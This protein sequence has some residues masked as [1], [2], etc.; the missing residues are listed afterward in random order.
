MRIN[1]SSKDE[2]ML[3]TVDENDA[4]EE[5]EN[6]VLLHRGHIKDGGFF[7]TT[8]PLTIVEDASLTG[9]ACVDMVR[10]IS[11]ETSMMI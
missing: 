7:G 6:C 11:A 10:V 4:D 8:Y 9:V 5:Q 3:A 2:V 1:S